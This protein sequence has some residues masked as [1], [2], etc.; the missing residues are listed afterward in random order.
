MA[1]FVTRDPTQPAFWDERFAAD[2][3]PWDARGAPPAFLRWLE[4]AGLGAG[5]RVLIPGC[6][7]A[8]EAAAL[9]ARGAEVLAID[10][11]PEAIE[12]A[13]GQLPQALAGRVLR[14]ADFFT[15]DTAPFNWIYERAF[16]AALPPGLWQRW[17]Q[18]CAQ[19][20]QPGGAIAGFFF[21]DDAAADPRRGPPFA[22]TSAELQRLLADAF[23]QVQ[24]L[25]VP[26]AESLPV[27]AG[28]E[29]WLQWRRR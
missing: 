22:I 10:Y 11:S 23:D 29:R 27:F 21:V 25:P 28:R 3:T 16:L 15:F 5:A 1:D 19:L 2:F 8:Y 18:R 4:A 7:A 9:D 6:G 14:Q 12:R 13:R 20:L 17:A 26:A 24:D